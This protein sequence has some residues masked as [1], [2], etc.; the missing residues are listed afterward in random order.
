M[1]ITGDLP[2]PLR[3]HR[4]PRR[5]FNES[6]TASLAGRVKF[7]NL[8]LVAHQRKPLQGI[9][10]IQLPPKILVFSTQ[11]FNRFLSTV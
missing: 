4:Q 11:E 10:V 5:P 7:E 9:W 3:L 6:S 8:T 1:K 2:A